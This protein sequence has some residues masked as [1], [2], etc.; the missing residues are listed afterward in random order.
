MHKDTAKWLLAFLPIPTFFAL[1]ITLGPRFAAID[2][3]G[4]IRWICQFW[5]AS[6]AIGLVLAAALAIIWLCCRV[7]LANPDEWSKLTADGN[8]RWMSRAFS[9]YGVGL[10]MFPDA[11]T[12][13][14]T[15]AKRVAN[16]ATGDEI[17]ALTDTTQRIVALSADLK[18]RRRFKTFGW[19]LAACAVLIA[20]GLFVISAALPVTPDA[21]TKPTKVSIYMP[22]GTESKFT[23]ATGC[24]CLRTTTAIAVHGLWDRPTLRV[25]G[26]GCRDTEWTPSADLHAVIAP[27]S[28]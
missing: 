20:G 26:N 22:P 27:G 1:G 17:K 24:T 28:A 19:A 2:E 23:T 16:T 8:K 15:E 7:L 14:S 18:A 9:T 25:F 10:P 12:F 13:S 6:L 21:V 4:I 11:D 5:V 3:V